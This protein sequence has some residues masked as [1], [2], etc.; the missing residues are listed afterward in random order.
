MSQKQVFSDAGSSDALLPELSANYG[1]LHSAHA[2]SLDLDG[3]NSPGEVLLSYK[4]VQQTLRGA[5]IVMSKPGGR[6]RVNFFGGLPT[7]DQFSMDL[8]GALEAGLK[9]AS[10]RKGPAW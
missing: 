6:Y 8:K 5:G 4:Q 9:L 10:T 7:T 3:E 2:E 1:F